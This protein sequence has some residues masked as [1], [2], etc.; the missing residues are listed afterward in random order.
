MR[1]MDMKREYCIER[2]LFLFVGVFQI[3]A[4]ILLN[5]LRKQIYI[6]SRI[7]ATKTVTEYNLV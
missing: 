7:L 5:K 6:L 3:L 1:E 2:I 4:L